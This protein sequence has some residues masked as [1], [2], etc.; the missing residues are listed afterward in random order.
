MKI[1]KEIHKLQIMPYINALETQNTVWDFS[2]QNVLSVS[3]NR[4]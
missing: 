4:L 1:S 2:G 3:Y